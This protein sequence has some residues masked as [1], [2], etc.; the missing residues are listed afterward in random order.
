M[1]FQPK[2]PTQ[3]TL[4]II[5]ATTTSGSGSHITRYAVITNSEINI[6]SAIANDNIFPKVGIVDPE[7][8]LSLPKRFT[9]SCGFDVFTHA[10]ESYINVSASPMWVIYPFTL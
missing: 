5:C 9:R 8:V 6:K 7:L 4:P 1:F 3:K 2:Q 10:F